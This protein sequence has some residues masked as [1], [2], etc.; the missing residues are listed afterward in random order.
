M[1]RPEDR[2][3]RL[4]KKT[5]RNGKEVYRSARPKAVSTDEADIRIVANEQTRM[6]V[7]ANN[8]FGSAMEWWRIAAANRRVDGSIHMKPN[9]TVIIP[10]VT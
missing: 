5:L 7:L 9:Q 6:D 4:T 8:V 3:V 2:Y 10:K 1:A